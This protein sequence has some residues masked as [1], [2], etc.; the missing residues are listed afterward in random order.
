MKIDPA[1]Y[2]DPAVQ[3]QVRKLWNTTYS[4]MTDCYRSEAW[5][6]AKAAVSA[7]L[8]QLTNQRRLSKPPNLHAFYKSVYKA[9]I[10]SKDTPQSGSK[11]TW[12][13]QGCYGS[14]NTPKKRRIPRGTLGRGRG[15]N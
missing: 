6:A 2:T 9:H 1:L 3:D 4:H 12:V 5:D 14:W 11:D 13:S 15:R 8:I 7:L 10:K